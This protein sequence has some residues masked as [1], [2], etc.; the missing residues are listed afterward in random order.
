MA[1]KRLLRQIYCDL[2]DG[3]SGDEYLKKLWWLMPDDN[4]N[5]GHLSAI[6]KFLA[7]YPITKEFYA[8]HRA[9]MT[10]ANFLA[11]YY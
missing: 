1:L 3:L 9:P 11:V 7:E 5:G 10:K 8:T 6:H 4:G 2:H